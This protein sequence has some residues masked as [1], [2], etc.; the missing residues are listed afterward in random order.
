MRRLAAAL[1]ALLVVAACGGG[2]ALAT[3]SFAPTVGVP[4]EVPTI[5]LPTAGVPGT[6]EN[7]CAA[8]A[9]LVPA[10]LGGS[11]GEPQSGDVLGG[12]GVFCHFATLLDPAVN[13]E[14]QFDAMTE[15]EFNALAESLG[16]EDPMVGVG[17]SAFTREGAYTGVPGATVL[18]WDEGQGVTVLIQRDGDGDELREVARQ[19]AAAALAAN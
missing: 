10:A 6:A 4:D 3:P 9:P 19:I 1:V 18:A 15:A 8:M 17:R 16:V 11:A 7:L 12:E 2:G 14:V 13:V 5:G